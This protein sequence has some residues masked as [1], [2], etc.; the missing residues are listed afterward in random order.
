MRSR[1]FVHDKLDLCLCSRMSKLVWMLLFYVSS[2]YAIPSLLT[3]F[4]LWTIIVS[5]SMTNGTIIFVNFKNIRLRG[6]FCNGICCSGLWECTRRWQFLNW[7]FKIG[8]QLLPWVVGKKAKPIML[9]LLELPPLD[10][11][12]FFLGVNK[13]NKKEVKKL[14]GKIK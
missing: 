9:F 3:L 5:S 12:F 11:T 13:E 6:R 7:T 8:D 14:I 2:V 1:I 10:D 4:K